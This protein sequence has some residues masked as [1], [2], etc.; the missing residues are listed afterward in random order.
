MRKGGKSGMESGVTSST[1]ENNGAV[2]VGRIS[3]RSFA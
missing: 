1:A 3:G 2:R